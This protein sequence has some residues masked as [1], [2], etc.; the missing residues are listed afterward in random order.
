MQLIYCSL[1]NFVLL[2]T[3]L[4]IQLRLPAPT[5]QTKTFSAD[6]TSWHSSIFE[7]NLKA[8]EAEN[9]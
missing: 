4:Q 7:Y 1:A 5:A 9:P 8:I 6:L 2:Q 3:Y